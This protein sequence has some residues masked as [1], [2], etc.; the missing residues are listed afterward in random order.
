MSYLEKS[1]RQAKR[2]LQLA[3][4]HT[5]ST[6]PVK[7]LSEAQNVI[8]IIDG[9]NNWHN[10]SE[11][12]KNKDLH[13]KP[14]ISNTYLEIPVKYLSQ[15]YIEDFEKYYFNS[16]T[17]T[18][19]VFKDPPPKL[20]FNI[21]NT[22]MHV[23]IGYYKEKKGWSEKRRE[24]TLAS[25]HCTIWSDKGA[26][27]YFNK[28][29]I[30]K[31]IMKNIGVIY[32]DTLEDNIA[33]SDMYKICKKHQYVNNLYCLNFMSKNKSSHS[34]D[35][36]N[37]LIPYKE[38]FLNI[39][40]VSK[41]LFS[42]LFYKLCKDCYEANIA[43]DSTVIFHFL[44]IESLIENNNEVLKEIFNNSFEEIN[45]YLNAIGVNKDLSDNW[46][47]NNKEAV[48][49]HHLQVQNILFMNNIIKE[50][51]DRG[52]FSVFPQ[53]DLQNIIAQ[54]KVLTVLFPK[55]TT[56]NPHVRELAN[57]FITNL[58]NVEINII[59]TIKNS[60]VPT[61]NELVGFLAIQIFDSIEYLL[62]EH[63]LQLFDNLL[64]EVYHSRK[65]LSFVCAKDYKTLEDN[66][67]N[68]S[69]KY[70]LSQFI[71]RFSQHVIMRQT[72]PV[73]EFCY[74]IKNQ[75]ISNCENFENIF[76]KDNKQ[77]TELQLNE[78][79]FYK[80]AYNNDNKYFPTG[81]IYKITHYPPNTYYKEMEVLWIDH[82]QIRE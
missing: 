59:E 4:T 76:H 18:I 49:N 10:Y 3:K 54:N 17:K 64:S 24:I 56:S 5:E 63:T 22:G 19:N 68:P 35:P 39:F 60:I 31:F 66:F 61:T 52:V 55:L 77:L 44:S 48:Q 45:M 46:L 40:N 30:E 28:D 8:A 57:I 75:I 73:T 79:Y 62:N 2:L 9:Y 53:I 43:V 32:I 36:I 12:L 78:L 29:I 27:K 20:S 67:T 11:N 80:K 1:K 71:S 58:L 81:L 14:V 42:D 51:E 41:N 38:N 21:K 82:K 6:I 23:P 25:H 13:N 7:T 15:N 33:Y 72:I 50:Y 26:A 65:M 16:P 69:H 37:P 74:E 47:I 34:I 70:L